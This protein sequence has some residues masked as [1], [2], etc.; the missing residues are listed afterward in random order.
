MCQWINYML[1]NKHTWA[2]IVC[3]LHFMCTFFI[4]IHAAGVY[5][6]DTKLH[7]STTVRQQL[8]QNHQTVH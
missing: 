1:D 7:H 2:S 5:V 4:C 6:P 8:C 3:L